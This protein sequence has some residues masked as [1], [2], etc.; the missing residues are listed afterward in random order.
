MI[1]LSRLF[2]KLEHFDPL[3]PEEKSALENS[4]SAVK[5]F[6]ARQDLIQEGG[7]PDG[8]KI[9]LDGMAFRYKMLPD[10][11]RQIVGFFLPGDICDLRAYLLRRMD[12]SVAAFG[13]VDTA[14]LPPDALQNLTGRF[15]RLTRALWWST[16]VDE[17]VAR[18]WI[19]NVG[20]RTAFERMAHL[21][22][23]MY[24]RLEAVELTQADSFELPLT[25]TELADTLAL[26]PVHV[27]RT[28]MEMRRARLLS[29][30]GRLLT[31]HNL[32]ELQSLAGFDTNYLHLDNG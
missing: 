25:Q 22:C 11:R 4:V 13:S 16:L 27:N 6:Q 21:F 8:V 15:P 19:V 23:E 9:I 2:R 17:A 26:S 32:P 7:P 12:H 30:E 20:F 5:Q 14:V 1:R 24:A 18:E 31:I 28:L 3:P 29:F 10:G